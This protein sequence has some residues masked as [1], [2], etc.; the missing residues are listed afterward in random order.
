MIPTLNQSG[1]L[2]PFV[3]EL[4]P[5]DPA[6]MAPYRAS[7][8]EFVQRYAHS[9]KRKTILKGFLTYRARLRALGITDGFQWLDG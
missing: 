3:P 6:G 1:V 7:I 5:T 8:S 2:P 4:G 9:N